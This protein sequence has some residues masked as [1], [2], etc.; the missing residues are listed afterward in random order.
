MESLITFLLWPIGIIILFIIISIM[1]RKVVP[2]NEVHIVQRG[3]KSVAYGKFAEAEKGWT[4]AG[5]VYLA[6]PSWVP[7][8]WVYVKKLPLYVFDIKLEWYQAYDLWKVPFVV[9]V[10][11]FFYVHDPIKAASKIE[12]MQELKNQLSE[13]LKWVIRKVLASK[14]IIEIMESRAEIKSEFYKEVLDAV[15]EWWVT[16]KNVEFMDIR[17]PEDG[18]SH[19]ISN[20]MKKKRSQ[21][22]ADSQIEVAENQKRATIEK[23]NKEAEARAQAAQ[24]KSQADIIEYEARKQAELKK[25]ENEKLIENKNIEKEE[26]IN[27]QKEETKQRI[28]EKAKLTKEKELIVKQVEEEK[29]ADI[30]K[31]IEIIKANKEKEKSIIDA[32]A[33]K[34]TI[35]L[36]AEAEKIK[37]NKAAEAEAEKIKMIWLAKAKEVDFLGTAEAKN[38]LEMAKALNSFSKDAL[39]YMVKELD[40][41]VSEKVDF[42]KARA[43]SNADIKV[44][45][46][47]ANGWDWLESFMQLFSA[48]GWA[49]L[50]AMVENLKNTIWEEKVQNLISNITKNNKVIKKTQKKDVE[51][52]K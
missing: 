29:K 35:E 46:T 20:I 40:V 43:L 6:W 47:W 16:S 31:N 48:K 49:N 51:K 37:I 12:D 1:L 26:V 32:Q 38:K 9:D 4:Y 33:E 42:E 15:K 34:T 41:K 10:T 45:S 21:I 14:D 52:N 50:W 17:D 36:K 2:T 18:T 11:A 22:E 23:E 7:V 24:S 5:N 3:N 27:I 25:I 30:A 39:A 8:L 44:I 28:Y 13:T 19:V